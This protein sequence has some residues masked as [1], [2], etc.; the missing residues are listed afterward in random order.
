MTKPLQVLILEDNPDDADL[1][2]RQLERAGFEPTWTRVDSREDYLANL[3]VFVDV[4]LADFVVPQFDGL[5]ALKLLQEQGLDTP[6]LVVTGSYEELGIA[7]VRQGAADYVVKDKMDRLGE[8]VKRAL[9]EK[10]LREEKHRVEQVMHE[11]EAHYRLLFDESRDAIIVTNRYGRIIELNPAAVGLFEYDLDETPELFERDLHADPEQ[12]QAVLEQ[13]KQHGA[14]VDLP[15]RLRSR[16]GREIDCLVSWTLRVDIDGAFLG[17][18]G[19]IR[20]VSEVRRLES[21]LAACKD[22]LRALE[23]GA[24]EI[25]SEFEPADEP[26]VEEG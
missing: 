23:L 18:R 16:S 3:D 19:I 2:I 13:I 26:M 20:D 9:G 7:C 15:L 17:R 10:Q 4:V 6:F 8:A 11:R 24:G 21:E 1:M 12:A 25:Q 22:R 5:S 14:V